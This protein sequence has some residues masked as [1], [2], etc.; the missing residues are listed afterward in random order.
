VDLIEKLHNDFL[1]KITLS[2]KSTPL[3]MLLGELGRYPLKIIIKSRMVGFWKRLVQSK[4]MKLSYLLY[5]SLKHSSN[6][7]SK[8]IT[9]IESI[10]NEI[11]RPDIWYSQ[12][13]CPINPL[14]K[15]VKNM[16][17]EQYIQQWYGKAE[18]SFKAFTYFSFKN[19]YALEKYFVLLPRKLYIKLFKLRT[20]N[21]KL[22]VETGRWDGIDISE[23]KCSLCPLNDTG[24][25]FHYI[26]KCPYFHTERQLYLKPYYIR[27]PSMFKFVQLLQSKSTSVLTKLSKFI[28]L[29]L[30]IFK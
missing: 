9:C 28:E 21:H 14:S 13:N 26:L 2:K 25:E 4:E 6:V 27:R 29:I 22:P 16:L 19:E 8:W 30:K 11:G 24:D 23:R 5:Q 12:R 10:F 15:Y 17:I 7:K 18:H 1:R 3:Y 20:G